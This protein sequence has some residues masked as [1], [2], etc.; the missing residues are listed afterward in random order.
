[1]EINSYNKICNIFNEIID[2]NINTKNILNLPILHIQRNHDAYL[3]GY[4]DILNHTNKI[5]FFFKSVL[6]SVL[7]FLWRIFEIF[8]LKKNPT[9][10]NKIKKKEF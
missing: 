10:I 4:H 2:K 7:Y 1:M 3:D 6:G 9:V 8:F 5:N